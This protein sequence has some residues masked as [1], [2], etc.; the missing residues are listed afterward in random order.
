MAKPAVIAKLTCQD[1]KRA[2]AVKAF[3]QMF[4]H[5]QANESGTL[6]YALHEDAGDPNV[7]YFYEL[8]EDEEAFKSHSGSDMMKTVGK[9][10][11]DVMAARPELIMLNPVRAKGIDV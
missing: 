6:V 3:G 8:Y 7:L 4:D 11:R 10:L 1:G 5:V 9:G 2:E